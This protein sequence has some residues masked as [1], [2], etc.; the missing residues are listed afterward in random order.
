M[1]QPPELTEVIRQIINYL[2]AIDSAVQVLPECPPPFRCT[3]LDRE[4]IN[5]M[6][7]VE[8]HIQRA[9]NGIHAAHENFLNAVVTINAV[10]TAERKKD[11]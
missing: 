6:S 7:R 1:P 8:D 3:P 10:N 2:N 11:A 9:K 4:S 5:S